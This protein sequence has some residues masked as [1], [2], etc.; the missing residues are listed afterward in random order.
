MPIDSVQTVVIGAGVIGLSVARALAI[1]GHEVIVLEA[2]EGIGQETS[3]RNSEVIH[4]GL[5]Y[6]PGSL[7]AETCIQGRQLLY[8]YCRE[9]GVPY[10]RVGKL[11]LADRAAQAGTLAGL[12]R[13]AEACG[14]QDLEWITRD[15]LQE[16]EPKVR[17]EAALFSPSTGIIDC[18]ALMLSLQA[19]LEEAGGTVVTRCLVTHGR[20]N[21]PG[22]DLYGKN[23]SEFRLSAQN[24]INAA[25]LRAT[26]FA[27]QLEGFPKQFIPTPRF[28]KGHY[29]SYPGASP[30]THL[31]Y[32]LPDP[33]GLGI[34]ATLDLA[35]QLRFGPDACE[36]TAIDY[37]F[38]E[39]RKAEFADSVSRWFP[40]LD[41]NRLQ[42]GYT[43]I[44]PGLKADGTAFADFTISDSSEHGVA[45]MVN[46]FGIESPGLTACL[47]LAQYVAASTG[48]P[49]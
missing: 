23:D 33:D 30:F 28:V 4:A 2:Q 16:M 15:R 26:S 43:G 20:I 47:A 45:G 21:R 36:C 11:I 44:R 5:Y 38:D 10:R 25:G 1:A 32:P 18:H 29:F 27:Q 13:N 17:A 35:G 22:I 9:R 24:V 6:P 12:K 34:H 8:R 31:V 39:S 14:V 41:S 46:L 49:T 48:P 3:S 40:A 37:D 42:A 7:K 19:D